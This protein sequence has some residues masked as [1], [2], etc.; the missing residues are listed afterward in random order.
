MDQ[1]D[2]LYRSVVLIAVTSL[3]FVM[4]AV[5]CVMLFGLFDTRVDNAEIFK[6]ILPAFSMI[7][8]TFGGLIGGI[9]IGKNS[10]KES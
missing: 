10:R 2:F 4:L 6:V 7:V 9:S 5:T 8:G 1:G 3:S